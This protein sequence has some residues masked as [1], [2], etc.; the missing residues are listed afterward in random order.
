MSGRNTSPSVDAEETAR[1]CQIYNNFLCVTDVYCQIIYYSL[2]IFMGQREE[3]VEPL[4]TN[5]SPLH[6]FV[7]VSSSGK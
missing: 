3:N 1:V 6:P 5:E 4:G 7:S 2:N